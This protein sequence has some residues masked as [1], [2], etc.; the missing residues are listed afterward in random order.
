VLTRADV[1]ELLDLD[2]CIDAVETAFARHGAGRAVPPAVVGVPVADGGFHVKA[3]GLDL[4]RAYF[5]AKVNANFPHNRDRHGLPTIQGAVILFDGEAGRV[6]AILDS[7]EITV[8]RTAAA[9]AVAARYL[10]RP[11][12]SVVTVCGCGVQGWAQLAA[13]ER[14]RPLRRVAAWDADSNRAAAYARR[15][16]ARYG[17][18]A[19]AVA[20]PG[21]A[22]RESDVV[23]TCTPA[24]R[25]FLGREHVR[26][27]AFVAAVGADNEQKQELEP[28]LVAGATLVVDVLEQAATIGDLHHALAAGLMTRDQVHAE[29]GAIVAG[30]KPGRRGPE[31]IIVFDSTGTALLDVAAAAIVYERALA[32]G[33]GIRVPLG[34]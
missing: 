29:L 2:S 26:G 5:A 21:P 9:T 33:R 10:A 17:V 8:Q 32:T 15:A 3:A 25:W 27:G 22:A 19:A 7:I 20:A 6:L 34:A 23:L 4:S 31:E 16:A 1:A 12:E 18:P 30:K 28:E 13:L 24:S 14:V 11:V